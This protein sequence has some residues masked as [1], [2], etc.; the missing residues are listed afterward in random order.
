MEHHA[1][2]IPIEILVFL[3]TAVLAPILFKRL[4]LGSIV[5]YLVFGIFFGPAVLGIF[6]DPVRI[7]HIAEFGVVLLLF[8]IGLEIEPSRWHRQLGG[9]VLSVWWLAGMRRA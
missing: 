5:G 9:L 2:A 1:S 7:L 6:K 4:G 3:G 8:L